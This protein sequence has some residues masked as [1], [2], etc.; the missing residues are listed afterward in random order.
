MPTNLLDVAT[1]IYKST[2]YGYEPGGNGTRDM[3]G[4]GLKD[5]DCSGMVSSVLRAAGYEFPQRDRFSTDW[6]RSRKAEDYFEVIDKNNVQ[7]GDIIVWGPRKGQ[8][9][10]HTG[11]VDEYDARSNRGTLYGSNSNTEGPEYMDIPLDRLNTKPENGGVK[12]LRPKKAYQ[13][14]YYPGPFSESDKDP[15]HVAS[16]SPDALQLDNDDYY[17]SPGMGM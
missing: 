4:D 11:F 1:K 13:M 8:K 9:Y 10:G 17:F 14:N 6:L 15:V 16:A 2:E 5:I 3:N 7:P 12:F